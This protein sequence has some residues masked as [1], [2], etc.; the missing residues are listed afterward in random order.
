MPRLKVSPG[1]TVTFETYDCFTNRLLPPDTTYENTPHLPGNPV[2]GPLYVDTAMPGDLLKI[3]ILS[4]ETGPVGVVVIGP[5]S[6]YL[7][8]HFTERKLWRIPVSDGTAL[9]DGKISIPVR[10]MI[11]TI[12]LAPDEGEYISES[13]SKFGGNMDCT[14]I[15]EGS[16]LYLPV[17]V[18]GGLLSMGDVHAIM[19]DGES[20]DCGLEIEADVTVRVDLVKG[21][22]VKFPVL[23]TYDKWIVIASA[24]T[25]EESWRLADSEMFDLLTEKA[26]IDTYNAGMLLTLTGDLVICQTVNPLMTVRM[27]MPAGVLEQFGF[28]AL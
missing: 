11:G 9:I 13:P 20:E 27:E 6:G 21:A 22:D 25:V 8:D 18:E 17:G 2:T 16:V 23:R 14:K 3:E 1:D 24:D 4:I 7:K 10:P 28:T 15:T 5:K 12:G 19:G 26:H